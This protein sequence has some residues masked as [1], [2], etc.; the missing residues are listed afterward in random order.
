VDTNVARVIRR[1]FLPDVDPK[2]GRGAKA[3]WRVAEEILP[4]RGR[5]AWTHNQALMELG[6][7]VC[8]ARARGCAACPV[9]RVCLTNERLGCPEARP[10]RLARRAA[11]AAGA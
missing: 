6:A 11:P 9:R 1:V 4:R 10:A 2:T 5:D 8:T 7:L 3:I